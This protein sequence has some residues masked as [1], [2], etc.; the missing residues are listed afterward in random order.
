[1]VASSSST[2]QTQSVDP[3]LPDAP[4]LI[5]RKNTLKEKTGGGIAPRCVAA[6]NQAAENIAGEFSGLLH[7]TLAELQKTREK[8][9]AETFRSPVSVNASPL[10]K[11]ALDMKSSGTLCGYPL[12]TRIAHSLCRLLTLDHGDVPESLVDA[13]INT[14]RAILREQIKDE[15]LPVA[16]KLAEE[17]ENHVLALKTCQ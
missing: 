14:L 2:N 11:Y 10:F 5:E 17:L 7:E 8:A 6:A 16:S 1:M 3:V 13:H 12:V 15:S 9:T 4:S